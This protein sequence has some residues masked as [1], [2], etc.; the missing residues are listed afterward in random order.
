MRRRGVPRVPAWRRALSLCFFAAVAGAGG[1]LTDGAPGTAWLRSAHTLP[2]NTLEASLGTRGGLG[3]DPRDAQGRAVDDGDVLASDATLAIGYGLLDGLQAGLAMPWHL[4]RRPDGSTTSGPGDLT[5]SLQLRYP[6]YRVPGVDD[7]LFVTAFQLALGLPTG[8]VDDGALPRHPFSGPATDAAPTDSGAAATGTRGGRGA[9]SA[10]VATL[11]ARILWT[12]D[13]QGLRPGGV[14][15]DDLALHIDA[16]FATPADLSGPAAFLAGAGAIYDPLSWAGLYLGLEGRIALAES[17]RSIPLLGH[18]WR[19]FAGVRLRNAAS[20]L[21][22]A[23]GVETRTAS[24]RSFDAAL[25]AAYPGGATRSLPVA[26]LGWHLEASW[27][28]FLGT[29]DQ[30]GDGAADRADACPLLAED[31]DGFQDGDGCP[32]ADN[33][34]DGVP[35]LSDRCVLDPETRNG[36]RDEDGCPDEE[37]D[38]DQ[39]G[40]ADAADGCPRLPED[41]DGFQDGDGCPESDN[42]SD[43][44]WDVVDRCPLQDEDRDGHQDGD[45]CPDPDNDSDAVCDE[46]VAARGLLDSLQGVCR[47]SD[48][49]PFQREA[50]NGRDDEDGCPDEIVANFAM[51]VQ[52]VPGLGFKTGTAEPT[53]EARGRL[54]EIARRI[55]G[56]PGTRIVLRVHVERSARPGADMELSRR[57]AEALRA[58]VLAEGADPQAVEIAGLG[59]EIPIVPGDTPA[60]RARNSRV[61]IERLR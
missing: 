3:F 22:L 33:D 20:G 27:R 52:I 5:L 12:L 57:R 17:R 29:R 19:A 50:V 44:V 53:F 2:R 49:C 56:N 15:W 43:G 25:P 47:G 13:L 37:V 7:T 11:A 24:T 4:D 40:Y 1:T 58:I 48:R 39:D 42:D 9:Y 18:P 21:A 51:G 36:A 32:D 61:E 26:R 28:G 59:S 14:R 35:D 46:W 38:T 6:P 16:G 41:K 55:R 30:D 45:G 8:A 10:E 60:A 34:G 31:R 54:R 23:G